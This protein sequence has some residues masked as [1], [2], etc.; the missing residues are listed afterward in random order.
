[1]IISPNN[2]D[3]ILAVVGKERVGMSHFGYALGQ[4]IGR[5]LKKAAHDDTIWQRV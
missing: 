3:S 4:A 1:M 2:D 5:H